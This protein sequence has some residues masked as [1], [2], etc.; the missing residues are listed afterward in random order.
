MEF[1]SRIHSNKVKADLGQLER[2]LEA[3]AI[4]TFGWPIA[5]VIWGNEEFKPRPISSD[6]IGAE[7]DCR[8]GHP[9]GYHYDV[10][11]LSK[12]GKFYILASLFEDTRSDRKIF[13]D[14]RTI[15]ITE[16]LVRTAQLYK[17]LG[18]SDQDQMEGKIE[19]GGLRGRS[20]TVASTNRM[21]RER[22]CTV[23]SVSS[24]IEQTVGALLDPARLKVVVFDILRGITEVCELFVPD[25][26]S[27]IDPIVENYLAGRIT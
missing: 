7:I 16:T 23:E 26:T 13:L 8:D 19:H 11:T 15:R 21:L 25:K 6:A 4:H 17:A 5:P 24:D 27:V 20:L 12:T 22:E 2:A 1:F 10:W 3:T 18:A 14:T 9:L